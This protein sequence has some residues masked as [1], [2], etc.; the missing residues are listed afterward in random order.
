[1][2]KSWFFLETP[3]VLKMIWEFFVEKESFLIGDFFGDSILVEES[4]SNLFD[5]SKGGKFLS[6]LIGD[7]IGANFVSSILLISKEEKFILFSTSPHID[8][9][10]F[11]LL[12]SN[13]SDGD[14]GVLDLAPPLF[15]KTTFLS[16]YS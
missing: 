12:P 1:M 15:F 9:N 6:S 2:E 14:G 11:C 5:L 10:G 3:V 8:V 4:I 13:L 16:K 7:I